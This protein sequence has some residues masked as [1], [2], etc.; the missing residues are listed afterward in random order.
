[1]QR[2]TSFELPVHCTSLSFTRIQS[3]IKKYVSQILIQTSQKNSFESGTQS[4]FRSIHSHW[5][6]CLIS[7][8]VIQCPISLHPIAYMYSSDSKSR[9]S[10]D[11]LQCR[12]CL[13]SDFWAKYFNWS[14][15]FRHCFIC[16]GYILYFLA[17][18]Y[19]ISHGAISP[20]LLPAFMPGRKYYEISWYIANL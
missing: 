6:R 7:R 1:M 19:Y 13:L 17:V 18:L 2:S 14:Y 4:Q 16:E 3:I 12:I 20:A 10:T 15:F 8:V 11:I 9:F 5:A